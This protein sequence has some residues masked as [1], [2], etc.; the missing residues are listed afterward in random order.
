LIAYYI[1]YRVSE[2]NADETEPLI[3]A[4]QARMACRTGI[5]GCLLKKRDEPGLWMEVYE[6]IADA[7]EFEL[8]LAQIEDE[9]DIGMFIDGSRH[10]E[11]FDYEPAGLA[12]CKSGFTEE[13]RNGKQ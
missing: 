8:R 6:A 1:Y 4:M 5:T 10:R 3:R 12:T 11:V 13:V 9:F 2:K 7:D